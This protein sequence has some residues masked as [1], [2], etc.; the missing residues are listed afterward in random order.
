MCVWLRGWVT[1]IQLPCW[2]S[3]E[4]HGHKKAQTQCSTQISWANNKNWSTLDAALA[5]WM[6]RFYLLSLS[7]SW[8]KQSGAK[9][10]RLPRLL[11]SQ[12]HLP[13]ICAVVAPHH[14]MSTLPHASPV[15][16]QLFAIHWL[17]MTLTLRTPTSAILSPVL[18]L[19]SFRQLCLLCNFFCYRFSVYICLA[20]GSSIKGNQLRSAPPCPTHPSNSS[21]HASAPVSWGR[22]LP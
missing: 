6:S 12:H 22:T 11:Q 7:H 20:F 18:P 5:S 2:I 19:P 1:Q 9:M 21:S 14:T 17:H 8:R 15:F 4:R 3:N 16:S 10:T 13:H